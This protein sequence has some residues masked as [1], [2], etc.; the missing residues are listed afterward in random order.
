MDT[1]NNSLIPVFESTINNQVVQTVDARVLHEFLEVK[2]RFND[3][4]QR[5]IEFY[6][7]KQ[8]VDFTAILS[9]EYSPPRKDYHVTVRMAKELA[10]VE[11]N[12]KGSEA[13]QYFI[14]IEEAYRNQTTPPQYANHRALTV[15]EQAAS[16]IEQELKVGSLFDVP[17]HIVQ[18]EAVKKVRSDTGVDYSHYL[19]HAPAQL[20]IAYEDMMLEPTEL[21][22]ALGLKNAATANTWLNAIGY[23]VKTKSG[24]EP[25]ESGK[26]YCHPHAWSKRGKSG[27]NLRWNVI[28]IKEKL[29]SQ[30]SA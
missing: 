13:R 6:S 5:Q 27:Y 12:A 23:Q 10:M 18:Q 7:F 17:V 9:R 2:S 14:A 30:P 8:D 26:P 1:S 29:N 3:W 21:S 4:I 15:H 25:T 20:L 19:I 22:G 16:Q 24:W 28:K 11:R